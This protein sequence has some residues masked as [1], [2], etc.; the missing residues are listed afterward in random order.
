MYSLQDEL[1]A[2]LKSKSTYDPITVTDKL[3]GISEN[4]VFDQN[5]RYNVRHKF[6]SGIGYKFPICIFKYRRPGSNS[7]LVVVFKVQKG[8][9][10]DHSDV[11]DCLNRIKDKCESYLTRRESI[12]LV[13]S[14]SHS[15][16]KKTRES[17]LIVNQL[18]KSQNTLKLG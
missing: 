18:L 6:V 2:L 10:V 7:N 12:D 15:T 4:A 11:V 1:G 8:V 16:G 14:I 13:R 5:R 3:M 9:T 17:Q